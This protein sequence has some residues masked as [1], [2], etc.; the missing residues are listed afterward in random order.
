MPCK[1]PELQLEK[2]GVGYFLMHGIRQSLI[3]PCSGH[4]LEISPTPFSSLSPHPS[5]WDRYPCACLLLK[6]DNIKL[7]LPYLTC[8]HFLVRLTFSHNTCL[9]NPFVSILCFSLPVCLQIFPLYI[10]FKNKL[11]RGSSRR[12]YI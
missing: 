8:F 9:F 6:Y 4:Q 11:Y 7:Q 10:F 1:L 12:L 3:L 5:P 2:K